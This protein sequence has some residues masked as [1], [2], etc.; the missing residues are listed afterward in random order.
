[1][2]L[3]FDLETNGLLAHKNVDFTHLRFFRECRLVSIAYILLDD[4]LEVV[5]EGYHI[6][7][8]DG[9]TISRES[10]RIHGI[11]HD[12]AINHG[13]DIRKILDIVLDLFRE[14]NITHLVG[15]NV[16]FDYTVLQSEL[17]RYKGKEANAILREK[18]LFCTM[19]TG[20]D[21]LNLDKFPKL[22]ALYTIIMKKP[23][24]NAHNAKADTWACKE[25]FC[26]MLRHKKNII[27]KKN[28]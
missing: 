8:P 26:Y 17:F 15:H 4:D 19:R 18:E 13:Q 16:S 2:Y 22:S 12:Y 14:F 9:Y 20:Q 28:E 11:E 25:C 1:M 23:L 6:A 3:C 10:T 5:R 27:R 24:E 21:L 7:K